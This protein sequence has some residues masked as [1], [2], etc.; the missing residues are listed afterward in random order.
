[1]ECGCCSPHIHF[2]SW[3]GNS[4]PAFLLLH[5]P[6]GIAG[7]YSKEF[8]KLPCSGHLR[9]RGSEERRSLIAASTRYRFA[10]EALHI[11]LQCKPVRSQT[12]GEA[13]QWIKD[14]PQTLKTYVHM[15]DHIKNADKSWFHLLALSPEAPPGQG[16]MPELITAGTAVPPDSPPHVLV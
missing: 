9:A 6:L 7:N 5:S 4:L 3:Y 15:A 1:M 10:C 13:H 12:V 8:S 11:S 2:Q 14:S 16:F